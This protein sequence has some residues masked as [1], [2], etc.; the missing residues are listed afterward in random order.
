MSG[1]ICE[2]RIGLQDNSETCYDT[3]YGLETVSLSGVASGRGED[4]ELFLLGIYGSLFPQFQLINLK[5]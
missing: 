1:L 5:F 2:R 3:V 4:L